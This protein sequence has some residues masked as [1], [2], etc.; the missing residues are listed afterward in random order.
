[1]DYVEI[2][3]TNGAFCALLV[4]KEVDFAVVSALVG[5]W[6]YSRPFTDATQ[7]DSLLLATI[8]AR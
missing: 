3:A 6:C 2:A 8:S 7:T 1:M 5:C 4:R